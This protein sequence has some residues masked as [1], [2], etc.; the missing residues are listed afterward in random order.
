MQSVRAFF[1]YRGTTVAVFNPSGNIPDVND[2]LIQCAMGVVR[3]SMFENSMLQGISSG[4]L[5]G[6][7]ASSLTAF[8]ISSGDVGCRYI[9]F[10]GSPLRKA[11]GSVSHT[12]RATIYLDT[13]ASFFRNLANNRQKS[14]YLVSCFQ[15]KINNSG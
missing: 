12:V 14:K 8:V 15:V 11:I 10:G 9:E 1:L 4:P 3:S 2:A 5:D 13:L 6:F 7:L